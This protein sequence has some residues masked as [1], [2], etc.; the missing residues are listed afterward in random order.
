MDYKNIRKS[1]SRAAARVALHICSLIIAFL[2][3]AWL[4]GFSR[5]LAGLGYVI[6]VRLRRIALESL[7]IAFG[8]ELSVEEREQIA[9]DSFMEMA[10]G[11]VELMYLMDKPHLIKERVS[12]KNLRFLTLALERGKG[13]ILVSAHFGNFPFILARLSLEGY[14]TG[15]IM[16][17][18]RDARVE[19]TFE[20]KRKRLGIRTIYSQPRR[21]CVETTIRSLRSNEM[22]FIPLDQ[23]FGTG[24][25]FVT[26]FGRKAA[27]ATGPVVLAKR[28]GAAVVPCFI[29]RQSDDTQTIVFEEPLAMRSGEK[30]LEEMVQEM[31][32]IIERYIRAYP[33]QWSWVHRRWKSQ[34][35]EG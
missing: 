8:D 30:A 1:L 23:N 35:K 12:F 28:T 29:I 19:Q 20:K 15:G 3:P 4:Y 14:K 31:T 2:P 7:A 26:F 16:R 27:T 32:G 13:A 9:R 11:G 17:P 10:K 5:F 24:G 33:A 18:M 6:A 21:V 22:V 34:P 25:V